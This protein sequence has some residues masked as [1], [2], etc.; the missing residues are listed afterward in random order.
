M[1]ILQVGPRWVA[2]KDLLL[3]S[4]GGGSALGVEAVDDFALRAIAREGQCMMPR[5]L[6]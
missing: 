6:D 5:A 1:A 2:Q 3:K 4:V